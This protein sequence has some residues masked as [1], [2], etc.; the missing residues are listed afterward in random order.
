[1]PEISR[2]V[3]DLFRQSFVFVVN[4]IA[5]LSIRY[6]HLTLSDQVIWMVMNG[7][8]GDEANYYHLRSAEYRAKME[9]ERQRP[10]DNVD[11]RLKF[12]YVNDFFKCAVITST[13]LWH[14]QIFRPK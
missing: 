8:T 2:A 13:N 14:I 9:G 4:T 10:C 12:Y 5:R 11:F 1:M 3:Y 7:R 6:D